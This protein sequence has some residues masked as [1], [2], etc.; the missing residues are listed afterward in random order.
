MNL[1][2]RIVS[3]R[4]VLLSSIL[5]TATAGLGLLAFNSLQYGQLIYT[6][7]KQTTF[8]FIDLQSQNILTTLATSVIDM[9]M[10]F[11]G[12][13]G[14][15]RQL[16]A[17]QRTS[18]L[19]MAMNSQFHQSVVSSG[20][21]KLQRFYAFN[22]TLDLMAKSSEGFLPRDDNTPICS[23]LLETA[24]ARVGV[25]RLKP[26]SSFCQR[27]GYGFLAVLVTVGT[28]KPLGYFL[29]VVDPAITLRE[30]SARLGGAPVRISHPNEEVAFASENW[31]EDIPGKSGERYLRIPFTFYSPTSKDPIVHIEVM[32]EIEHF[33]QIFSNI[34]KKNL[35]AAT[36]ILGL[37]VIL[38]LYCLKRALRALETVRIAA[39]NF[40]RDKFEPVPLSRFPEINSII[41]AFNSMAQETVQLIAELRT[42]RRDAER[43]NHSK[44]IF[45]ANMSHEIRTPMNAI[46]GYT[47]ILQ[48]DPTLSSQQRHGIDT[49]GRS[50]QQLLVLI[51]E[52]LDLSRFEAGKMSLNE[53]EFDLAALIAEIAGMYASHCKNMQLEW[54]YQAA[55]NFESTLPV[56]GDAEK[57]K[58]VL[59]IL[60]GNA[61]KFTS[62]GHIGLIATRN[63][64]WNFYFEV[65]DS[66]TGIAADL[67]DHIFDP[68]FQGP[69]GNKKGG[70]GLGL[71]IAARHVDLMGGHLAVESKLGQGSRFF[72]EL[73]LPAAVTPDPRSA[74]LAAQ[75]QSKRLRL[76][77]SLT[78]LVVDDIAVNREV[79]SALLQE[80][81]FNV[82]EADDGTTA[83]TMVAET[84]PDIIFM[85]YKMPNMNGDDATRQ[86]RMLYGHAIKVVM[87]TA[88]VYKHYSNQFSQSG[89]NISLKKPVTYEEI[90]ASIVDFFPDD[91]TE[92][93]APVLVDIHSSA[94]A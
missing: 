12:S 94:E 89:V 9:G 24:R 7:Q 56:Y 61:V 22:A 44:S 76:T 28:F 36:L 67:V 30:L 51:N 77:R 64:G 45:L 39:S 50:G 69:D 63:I 43:A 27:D 46:L 87:V 37:S 73:P 72:F 92:I 57:L 18:D 78:A 23:D 26:L 11:Q 42:A 59:L 40:S 29:I 84:S 60:L 33:N 82:V 81:G 2:K 71:A 70:T 55:S 86:I 65:F 66:G 10:I 75:N 13:D 35:L 34:S 19:L 16:I 17:D 32:Q 21:V 49:I 48:H 15:L 62:A 31:T 25:E 68:F 47:Q 91:F 83:I 88:S 8:G 52:I 58:Q 5:A 3:L 79:L 53:S 4:V 38:S 74:T 90:V 20:Q 93:D 6:N 14:T 80:I 41:S 85:D 1:K 54:R